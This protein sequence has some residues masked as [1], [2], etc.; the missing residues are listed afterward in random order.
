MSLPGGM[1]I[2]TAS[3][4]MQINI[5]APGRK[6]ALPNKHSPPSQLAAASRYNR[7]EL[8]ICMVDLQIYIYI[9]VFYG[10]FITMY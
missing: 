6:A 10:L 9:Y 4:P 1:E 8:R 5:F 7:P 3:V 2:T